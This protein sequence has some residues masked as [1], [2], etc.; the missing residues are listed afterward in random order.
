MEITFFTT[1]KTDQYDIPSLQSLNLTLSYFHNTLY[2]LHTWSLKFQ[3]NLFYWNSFTLS[4]LI[5]N[6]KSFRQLFSLYVLDLFFRS[7]FLLSTWK[8]THSAGKQWIQSKLT[9]WFIFIWTNL[10]VYFCMDFTKRSHFLPYCSYT[11]TTHSTPNMIS[12]NLWLLL[13]TRKD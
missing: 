11:S 13:F 8:S 4:Y 10:V 6:F 9:Q 12:Y 7:H 3:G 2:S 5:S 1:V